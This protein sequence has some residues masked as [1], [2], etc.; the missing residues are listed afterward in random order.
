MACASRVGYRPEAPDDAPARFSRFLSE[1][2]LGRLDRDEDLRLRAGGARSTAWPVE[3]AYQ[4]AVDADLTRA[5]RSRLE[6]FSPGHLS[7]QQRVSHRLMSFETEARLGHLRWAEHEY[8]CVPG[9]SPLDRIAAGLIE[10]AAF[11]DEE[12]ALVW[13]AAARD[14]GPW[15]LQRTEQVE[16]RQGEGRLA[17]R[18]ALAATLES[19][20]ALLP[21]DAGPWRA[22]FARRL[23]ADLPLERREDL[24]FRAQGAIEH[25]L[26]PAIVEW[27][28][29]VENLADNSPEDSGV[30]SRPDGE[31]YYA[32]LVRQATTLNL[33]PGAVHRLGLLEIDR[34]TAELIAVVGE[35]D[36]DGTIASLDELIRSRKDIR[37]IEGIH[38][39]W[40]ARLDQ[41]VTREPEA[42]VFPESLGTAAPHRRR[43]VYAR[44]GI[45]GAA[46]RETVVGEASTLPRFRHHLDVEAWS[47]GWDLYG[48]MLPVELGW[49]ELP[50]D[51]FGAI[52]EELWA[53]ALMV[54]DTGIHH[55]RWDLGR[56]R[57]WL[58]ARTA[59][60]EDRIDAALARLLI[61][62]ASAVG[63][64]VG[65]L[66]IRELRQ[67]ARRE[68]GEA[69]DLP[70]FHRIVLGQGPMPLGLLEERVL[71]W[72]RSL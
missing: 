36:H 19:S 46:L 44:S 45:P 3:A 72:S 71:N 60:P 56:A 42:V 61:E 67:A 15:L 28:E 66:R 64:P 20:R 69:F 7:L 52:Q 53:T 32:Y 70:T 29:L 12:G 59:E 11:E 49:I 5:E 17:P 21:S 10:G 24:L 16:D 58:V 23:P 65:C 35:V 2:H 51:R 63:A 27:T 50:S 33:S 9:R 6:A 22:A 47:G 40:T 1:V 4:R 18:Q 14:A 25:D 41:L 55:E 37:R 26:L 39:R 31:E 43:A 54:A 38:G 8:V 57:D 62:P 30:W 68:A 48:A 34:L 13:I